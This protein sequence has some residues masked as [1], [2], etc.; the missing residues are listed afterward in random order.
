MPPKPSV[1]NKS[2]SLDDETFYREIIKPIEPA[3]RSYILNKYGSFIDIEDVM[4]ESVIQY[5]KSRSKVSDARAYLFVTARNL[6]VNRIRKEK[7]VIW[8]CFDHREDLEMFD[9]MMS[10]DELASRNNEI[11]ILRDAVRS[12]PKKCQ[13]IFVMRK[14][15]EMSYKEIGKKL[16]ISKHSISTQISIGLSKCARYMDKHGRD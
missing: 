7:G 12:L 14:F 13:A 6:S 2:D 11:E 10:V 1:Q 5:F 3:V 4:Q 15:K 9:E 8:E 16:G